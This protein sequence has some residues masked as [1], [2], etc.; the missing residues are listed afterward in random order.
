MQIADLIF[1]DKLNSFIIVNKYNSVILILQEQSEQH[2]I[3]I[4]MWFI[5]ILYLIYLHLD[6]WSETWLDV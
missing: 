4:L 1:D 3:D 5:F 2:N 6:P